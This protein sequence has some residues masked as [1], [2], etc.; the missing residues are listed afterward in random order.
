[1]VRPR[2]RELR[3]ECHCARELRGCFPVDRSTESFGEDL[4]AFQ[5]RVV[6][7]KT[8][9]WALLQLLLLFGA[10]S[11]FERA[12]DLSCNP[13]LDLENVRQI[14]VVFVLPSSHRR[15]A[16]GNLDQLRRQTDAARLT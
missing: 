6:G 2:H 7:D 12:S 14:G 8:R 11:D 15:A 1:K 3:I 13:R 10:K 4:E 16:A 5:I 9:R